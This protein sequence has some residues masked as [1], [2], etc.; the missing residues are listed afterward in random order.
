MNMR[1]SCLW[2]ALAATLCGSALPV[3]SFAQDAPVATSADGTDAAAGPSTM[4]DAGTDAEPASTRNG[5]HIYAAFRDGLAEPDCGNADARWVRHFRHVPAR[6]A[7]PTSDALPLFGHVVDTLREAHLPTEFAL[8][9]FIESGYAPA[10][11]SSAGPA[12][13]WQFVGITA[14]NHGITVGKAYDGR[15]S[16]AESTRAAVR[17]LKTLNG[18]FAGNWRLAAMAY[19]AGEHRVLQSLRRSGSSASDATPSTVAGLSTTTYAYVEKLHALACLLEEAGEQPQWQATL[20]R[21]VPWLQPHTLDGVRSL[22]HW[23]RRHGGDAALLARINPA[24]RGQW[25]TGLAPL[26]LAPPATA[27]APGDDTAASGKAVGTDDATAA[28]GPATGRT[29]VVRRG[30]SAWTIARRHG[31]S[32]Q[33]LLELNSLDAR[34]V[35]K[36]GTALKLD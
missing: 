10:A 6:L 36:P 29:H 30:D 34:S 15:L 5:R 8:I 7:D 20:D 12:G 31:L 28:D 18:M 14:R 9:P 24:L 3:P 13:L 11:R 26:A 17:Y 27:A 2:A 35:L 22:D 21:P 16:P 32:T 23:A 4:D 1:H 19:N 33:R 25:P